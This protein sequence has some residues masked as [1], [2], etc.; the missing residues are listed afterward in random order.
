[1]DLTSIPHRFHCDFTS[2]LTSNSLRSHFGFASV[3]IRFHFNLTLPSLKTPAEHRGKRTQAGPLAPGVPRHQGNQRNPL[4][5]SESKGK[6]INTHQNSSR[7]NQGSSTISKHQTK[8]QGH[9]H[10]GTQAHGHT[11]GPRST[12]HRSKPQRQDHTPRNHS[13]FLV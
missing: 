7:N 3:S 1:M 10:T 8:G 4:N 12:N 9:G 13:D 11:D 5:P 2:G 6:L